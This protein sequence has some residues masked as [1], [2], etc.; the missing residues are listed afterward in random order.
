MASEIG[1]LILG[2]DD[3]PR[4]KVAVPEWPK[5][6][7]VRVRTI[8]SAERDRLEETCQ[9]ATKGG[10]RNMAN[11]RARLAVLCVCDEKGERIFKDE[12][13]EALGR[14]SGAALDRIA[15]V[16]IRLN[17]LQPDAVEQAEKNSGSGPA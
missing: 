13:A 6:R 16:A 10:P 14:K 2:E 7:E 9:P 8:S 12:D 5:V 15:D 4:E 1:D 17:R 11:F 3:L